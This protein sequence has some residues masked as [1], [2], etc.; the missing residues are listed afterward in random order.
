[1][2]LQGNWFTEDNK[3]GSAF[4]L[5]IESHCHHEKT[6][7][8]TI[9]IYK[10]KRFGYLM[11]IDG[12]TMLTQKENF[13]YHEMMSHVPL[14]S[15]PNPK[16]VV[17][18]GGGDCGTMR[19]CLKHPIEHITQIEIDKRVTELSEQYFPELCA[20]NQDPRVSLKFEDGID[21]M[22]KAPSQSADIIIVDSTDPVGPGEVLFN[23]PFYSE[24]S[25]VLRDNGI[26]IQQSESPLIDME[27]LKS[28]RN[29]MNQASFTEL[30]TFTF[31]Q[32]IYPTGF[33]SAT[34][35]SK[36]PFAS[37]PR[38]D[39]AITE[40]TQYYTSSIH[41]GCLEEIGLLKAL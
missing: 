5:E 39:S 11:A 29:R 26:L 25:R 38:L 3:K 17:I 18:I 28:M 34:M 7:F 4:S 12:F 30:L 6:P 35:A 14:L 21:W 13:F 10:T 23:T 27:L 19:E 16:Q 1:M 31:P 24:C 8:Q 33:W 22:R 40:S 41:Q 15:H 32:P 36:T 37:S 20:S 2:Q 9:D